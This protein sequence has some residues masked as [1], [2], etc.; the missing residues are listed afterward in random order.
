VWWC[1]RAGTPAPSARIQITSPPRHS[2]GT[3]TRSGI[4]STAVEQAVGRDQRTTERTRRSKGGGGAYAEEGVPEEVERHPR[5][6]DEE[7]GDLGGALE[8]RWARLGAEQRGEE[9]QE[10][11]RRGEA[12]AEAGPRAAACRR[13]RRH[14][15]RPLHRHRAVGRL[16]LPPWHPEQ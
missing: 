16:P 11:E 6:D 8:G 14:R 15:R 5:A 1:G 4:Q 2:A 12:E 7:E 10:G 13:E 3:R 9:E